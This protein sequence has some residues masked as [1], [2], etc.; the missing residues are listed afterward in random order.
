MDK[1]S[2]SRTQKTNKEEEREME[3]EEDIQCEEEKDDYQ[4]ELIESISK[5]KI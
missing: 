3:I 5:Q 1:F 2:N 4:D